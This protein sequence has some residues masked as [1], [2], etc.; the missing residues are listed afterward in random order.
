MEELAARSWPVLRS[1]SEIME[2]WYTASVDIQEIRCLSQVLFQSRPEDFETSEHA[3]PGIE[4][5]L[6]AIWAM[7]APGKS[8]CNI[9]KSAAIHVGLNQIAWL[10]Q[11][12]HVKDLQ[13]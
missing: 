12:S 8:A 5:V 13:G 4:A 7:E 11:T 6:N 1:G 9:K 3:N 10:R 2:P